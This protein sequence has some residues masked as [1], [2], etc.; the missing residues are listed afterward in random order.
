MAYDF[1]ASPRLSK[2]FILF[3]LTLKHRN[4]METR[5]KN[6]QCPKLQLRKHGKHR[7]QLQACCF[8]FAKL[9]V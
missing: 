1:T 5:R 2:G 9:K 6:I 7:G 4:P 3:K 8:I